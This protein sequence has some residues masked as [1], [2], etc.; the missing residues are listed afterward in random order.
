MTSLLSLH[1]LYRIVFRTPWWF[2]LEYGAIWHP[3]FF[4]YVVLTE[5]LSLF[6]FWIGKDIPGIKNKNGGN[7]NGKQSNGLHFFLDQEFIGSGPMA[8]WLSSRALLRRP[9]VSLVRILGTDM[10]L[11]L[12][13]C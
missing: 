10:A 3:V 1:K 11:L 6:D 9:W 4:S 13:P 12:Q 5:I 2:S 8:E 7:D